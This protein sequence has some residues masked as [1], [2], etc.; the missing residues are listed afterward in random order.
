MS[1]PPRFAEYV[2]SKVLPPGARG[3]EI[4]G[5]F[6]GR[7]RRKAAPLLRSRA[8]DRPSSRAFRK[9]PTC[10][11]RERAHEW[12]P[13]R[14]EARFSSLDVVTRGDRH[15]GRHPRSRDRREYR[16]F[17]DGRRARAASVSP[18]RTSTGWSCCGE[19]CRSK[20]TTATALSRRTISTGKRERRPSR[21]SLRPSGG[22]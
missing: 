20:A 21:S 10:Q 22:T 5:E 19:R 18:S 12:I 14:P 11:E 6:P 15:R 17:L 2:L 13:A 8:P 1:G 7:A 9:A 16:R 4:L 3:E